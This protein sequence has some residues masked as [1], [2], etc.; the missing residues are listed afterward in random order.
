MS[1]AVLTQVYDEM[2]RLAIAGSAVASGDFRLKKLIAPL[3]KS[4]EKA[5]VFAKVAQAT[6][7]VVESNEK[8]AAAALLELTTLV[9]AILYTQGET[10]L[11]GDLQPIETRDLGG[12][13]T[14]ASART[15]KPLLEALST[16]GSGRLELIR[17]AIERGAFR[18]LRLVRPAL[19]AIDD[20]YPEISEL[21]AE[22]VLPLYGQAILPELRAKFDYKG[23]A[24][25]LRRLSLMYR[26]DPAGTRELVKQVLD[27]GSKEL[28][29]AAIGCLGDSD[30]DLA[31]LL[32]QSK[33]KAK[34]VR[35][36]AL[37]ALTKLS[38]RDAIETLKKVMTTADLEMIIEGVQHSSNPELHSFVL[39][40]ADEQLATVLKCKDKK[41]QGAAITR[42]QKLLCCLD[43]HTEPD[44]EQFLL[45]C[46]DHATDFAAMKSEPSGADLN[47]LVGYLMAHATPMTRERLIAASG[48]VSG[49]VLAF[50]F[51]AAR[52]NLAPAKLFDMFASEL[53]TLPD[54]KSSKNA[55]VIERVEAL[56]SG[57]TSDEDI[58]YLCHWGAHLSRDDESTRIKLPALDPRWLD[59]AVEVRNWEAIQH[60]AR[61]GHPATNNYLSERIAAYLKKK[62]SFDAVQ[63]LETMIRV[64][65]PEAADVLIQVI[66]KEAKVTYYGYFGYWIGRLI[67]DLPQSA[68]PK[69]EALLPTLPDKVVDQLMESVLA[70][71][72]KFIPLRSS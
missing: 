30:E 18:D 54:K 65:H 7:A 46:F 70:L 23:K 24:G 55:A 6:R 32:E 48:N 22:K 60:L 14:Q 47:E 15:L 53:T 45:R 33:A 1:I 5:P 39:A 36:A 69:L 31:Y 2:R 66:Q 9:N 16:T 17:D 63:V 12:Q 50:A 35:A 67:P 10:G 11:R 57:L 29:V 38:V 42:L 25:H 51:F 64:Q 3:E 49:P 4:G 37:G 21:I 28:K 41:Q 68:V 20:P 52:I 58:T 19:L 72:N 56:V 44:T 8:T 43:E 61:A 34:D 40:Q 27:E 71:K 59:I 13:Q 62:D 26:L